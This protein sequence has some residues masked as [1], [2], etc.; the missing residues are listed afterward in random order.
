MMMK[1][2]GE[3][4][5]STEINKWLFNSNTIDLVLNELMTNGLKVEGNEKIGKL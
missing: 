3:E 2:V 4:I 5:S 1:N